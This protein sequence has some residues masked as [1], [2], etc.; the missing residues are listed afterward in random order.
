MIRTYRFTVIKDRFILRSK[1]VDRDPKSIWI[2][3]SKDLSILR[4]GEPKSKKSKA[5]NF[6]TLDFKQDDPV[7]MD[8]IIIDYD[9]DEEPDLKKEYHWLA[10]RTH[11]NRWRI[12]VPFDKTYPYTNEKQYR[13]NYKNVIHQI[14][15]FDKMSLATMLVKKII[16]TS[17]YSPSA[18]FI[19][20]PHDQPLLENKGESVKVDFT[21]RTLK[22]QKWGV[23]QQEFNK[24]EKLA[25]LK[26]VYYLMRYYEEIVEWSSIIPTQ[27]TCIFGW[28]TPQCDGALK[29][30][31]ATEDERGYITCFHT[32]C[33]KKIREKIKKEITLEEE[34]RYLLKNFTVLY[35]ACGVIDCYWSMEQIEYCALKNQKDMRDNIDKLQY[36]YFNPKADVHKWVKIIARDA[37]CH[38][39]DG[40]LYFYKQGCYQQLEDEKLFVCECQESVG[41]YVAY[42]AL[43]KIKA[44]KYVEEFSKYYKGVLLGNYCKVSHKDCL[45]F[46][47]GLLLVDDKGYNFIPHTPLHFSTEQKD[48]KYDPKAT[49]PLWFKT[50]IEYFGD[51]E[52]PQIKILQEYFGYCL[53]HSRWLE[54]ILFVFGITRSGKNTVIQMLLSL[55]P[56]DECSLRYAVDSEKRGK[57]MS[58]RN[59]VFINE[60]DGLHKI[61][62]VKEL[63]KISSTDKVNARFLYKNAGNLV[64]VPKLIIGFD[65]IPQELNINK[66]LRIRMLSVKFTKTFSGKEN[67]NLK[68]QLKKERSGVLN[69]ALEGYLR[70]VKNNKFTTYTKDSDFL[71]CEANDDTIQLEWLIKTLR[72]DKPKWKFSEIFDIYK[73]ETKDFDMTKKK[74][75]NILI[76]LGFEKDKTR[77]GVFFNLTKIGD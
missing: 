23:T 47:N 16:D 50:L 9:D 29:F 44:C 39:D 66:A 28:H 54:K 36:M 53:T 19:L 49:C 33:P 63:N 73:E 69:W 31:D 24:Y 3:E 1:V 72:K 18:F 68:K 5:W 51:L 45:N 11:S 57:Y 32:S 15:N 26:R 62:T 4:T 70:L 59:A 76:N 6:T 77:E 71:Y 75:S 67:T 61:R 30:N 42:R 22:K 46:K 2:R 55:V 12:I 13:D 8:G 38:K 60:I 43:G 52:S 25:I 58:G 20:R 48:F 65:D 14:F 35:L 27:S 10:H 7:S 74:L 40:Y 64:K 17:G 56:S 21:N 37:L 34:D 41:T